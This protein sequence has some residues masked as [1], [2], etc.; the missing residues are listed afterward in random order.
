M[1]LLLKVQLA[2]VLSQLSPFS[3]F[4]SLWAVCVRYT[5]PPM[6]L[7]FIY[8]LPRFLSWLYSSH[9][10]CRPQGGARLPFFHLHPKR[11]PN[12]VPLSH[13]RHL[14]SEVIV[15]LQQFSQNFKATF[16]CLTLIN[17]SRLT[18]CSK[19]HV[20]S[21][22]SSSWSLLQLLQKKKLQDINMNLSPFTSVDPLVFRCSPPLL[23]HIH[24]SLAALQTCSAE[25]SQHYFLQINSLSPSVRLRRRRPEPS[26]RRYVTSI[27]LK[28][29]IKK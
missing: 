26:S 7:L 14:S 15:H 19:L 29:A 13:R 20:L 24:Y 4:L 5:A 1:S 6:M 16:L 21:A 10:H 18:T 22:R 23:L 2:N 12:I 11:S 8:F 25:C 17:A 3:L 27:A 9:S 28:K